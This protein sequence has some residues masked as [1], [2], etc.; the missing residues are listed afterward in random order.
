VLVVAWD[1]TELDDLTG[2]AAGCICRPFGLECVDVWNG[3]SNLAVTWQTIC[4]TGWNSPF[5]RW[6][7]LSVSNFSR[8]FF[9]S[10]ARSRMSARYS[11]FKPRSFSFDRLALPLRPRPPAHR[12]PKVPRPSVPL[13]AVLVNLGGMGRDMLRIR[14]I[15]HETTFVLQ[16][17]G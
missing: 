7:W 17:N 1:H 13:D 2:R 4:S 14:R 8:K 3:L 10:A 16:Q 11:Y 9:S 5:V 6:T 12:L 15:R